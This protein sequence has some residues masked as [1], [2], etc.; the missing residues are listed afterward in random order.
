MPFVLTTSVVF[1]TALDFLGFGLPYDAPSLGRLI[2]QSTANLQAP[3]L[4][5]TAFF[6]PGVPFAWIDAGELVLRA[7]VNGLGAP[8]VAGLVAGAVG[9]LG[10]DETETIEIG[11]AILNVF[12]RTATCMAQ[13]AAGLDFVSGGRFILGLGASGPQVIEGFH[14]VP[15]EKPMPRSLPLRAERRRR[16]SKPSYLIISQALSSEA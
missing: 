12:S 15:Y 8:L 1:L 5:L 3:W 2:K 6:S 11:S 10:E 13:T 16:P 9:R 14:G 4:G 7:V